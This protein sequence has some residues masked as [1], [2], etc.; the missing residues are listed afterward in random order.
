LAIAD[1]VKYSLLEGLAE[2]ISKDLEE[3]C[4]NISDKFFPRHKFVLD[5][6]VERYLRDGQ[7]YSGGSEIEIKYSWFTLSQERTVRKYLRPPKPEN[8]RSQRQDYPGLRAG[9]LDEDELSRWLGNN[10]SLVR[11]R[12]RI[13]NPLLILSISVWLRGRVQFVQ[14]IDHRSILY[15]GGCEIPGDGSFYIS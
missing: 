4:L 9:I 2:M 6:T 14:E 13:I 15:H 7:W 8:C 1:L 10:T 12:E 5:H 11:H 3:P